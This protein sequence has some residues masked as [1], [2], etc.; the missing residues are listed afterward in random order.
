MNI[1]KTLLLVS[2]L[3]IAVRG[4]QICGD[5]QIFKECGCHLTCSNFDKGIECTE[6][7]CTEDCFCIDRYA[8]NLTGH[9]VSMFACPRDNNLCGDN[10]VYLECG[11]ACD[12]TC[13]NYGENFGCSLTYCR[14]GCHCSPDRVKGDTGECIKPEE[15]LGD[16]K[17][18]KECGAN[19][20]YTDCKQRCPETCEQDEYPNNCNDT[21]S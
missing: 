19:Q 10:Q 4:R 15:C 12:Q 18:D 6:D 2:T 8:R 1:L 11:R 21:C 13:D 20:F 9:C 14:A 16:V 3:L 7:I 5:K 17:G